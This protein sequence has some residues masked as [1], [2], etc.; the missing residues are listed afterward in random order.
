MKTVSQDTSITEER[1]KGQL[2]DVCKYDSVVQRDRNNHPHG[3][4]RDASL[5][6]FHPLESPSLV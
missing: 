4:L 3:P 2:K 5:P 6:S 1:T